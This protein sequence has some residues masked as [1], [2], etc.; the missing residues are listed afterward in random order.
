MACSC[1]D[2]PEIRGQSYINSGGS[3]S[4]SLASPLQRNLTDAYDCVHDE[5]E[6]SLDPPTG[7]ASLSKKGKLSVRVKADGGSTGTV[8]LI[9]KTKSHCKC[10]EDR[11]RIDC[12]GEAKKD[13]KIK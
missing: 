10:R 9:A 6:W 4:Y 1:E 2:R 7:L 12:Q 8:T 13:I 11:H 3:E 5:T